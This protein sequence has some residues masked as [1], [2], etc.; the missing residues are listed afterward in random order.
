[1]HI[2]EILNHDIPK[3]YFIWGVQPYSKYNKSAEQDF[4]NI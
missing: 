1:M 3:K 2:I 4:E